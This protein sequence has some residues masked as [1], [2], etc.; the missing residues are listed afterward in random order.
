[1]GK[2]RSEREEEDGYPEQLTIGRQPNETMA[3]IH[4]GKLVTRNV[5]FPNKIIFRLI[6]L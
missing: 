2:R 1:M 6:A 4:D 5:V 3:T